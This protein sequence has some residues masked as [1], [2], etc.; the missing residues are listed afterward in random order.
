[1]A[2]V[3]NNIYVIDNKGCQS[4]SVSATVGQPV[5]INFYYCLLLLLLVIIDVY[6][7]HEYNNKLIIYRC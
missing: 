5:G 2:G 6:Y 1:M 7:M 4:S 3:Y